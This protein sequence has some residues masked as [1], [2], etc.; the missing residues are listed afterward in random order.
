MR[1]I[2]AERRME[3]CS[4]FFFLDDVFLLRTSASRMLLATEFSPSTNFKGAAARRLRGVR[5]ILEN[6]FLNVQQFRTFAFNF[7]VC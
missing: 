7:F 4:T 6:D 5:D 3:L 2:E 1:S